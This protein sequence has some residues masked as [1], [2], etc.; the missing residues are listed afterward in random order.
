MTSTL[1]TDHIHY[2]RF[3]SSRNHSP[4]LL[5][6]VWM[7]ACSWRKPLVDAQVIAT[8][9]A[10]LQMTKPNLLTVTSPLHVHLVLSLSGLC[11]SQK[12]VSRMFR[13]CC[14]SRFSSAF[15]Y[16]RQ[17]MKRILKANV[18]WMDRYSRVHEKGCTPALEF[19]S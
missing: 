8:K 7:L 9:S 15:D 17:T 13:E 18:E 19:R 11:D 16:P 1:L 2:S 6:D 4:E 5:I 12:D 3:C 14:G 10:S